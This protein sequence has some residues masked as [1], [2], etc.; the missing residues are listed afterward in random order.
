MADAQRLVAAR[1]Q[2]HFR[3][4]AD[5]TRLLGGPDTAV[6]ETRHGVSSSFFE[7]SG[8]VRLG[9][10]SVLEHSL[11]QRENQKV[12]VLWRERG[13]GAPNAPLASLQ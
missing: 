7:V 9:D 4:L 5:V 13:A 6:T 8:Q 2:S 10:R 3:T 1:A 12:T 11:V